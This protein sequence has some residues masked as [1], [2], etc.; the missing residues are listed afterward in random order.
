[1]SGIRLPVPIPSRVRR[2]ASPGSFSAGPGVSSAGPDGYRQLPVARLLPG[3]RS[4]RPTGIL[5]SMHEA[6]PPAQRCLPRTGGSPPPD[7][8]RLGRTGDGRGCPRTSAGVLR[9]PGRTDGPPWPART[10]PYARGLPPA[11]YGPPCVPP[12]PGHTSAPPAGPAADPVE[13]AREPAPAPRFLAANASTRRRFR[14]TARAAAEAAGRPTRPRN[15]GHPAHHG[16]RGAHGGTSDRRHRTPLRL[17]G[18]RSS[19]RTVSANFRAAAHPWRNVPPTAVPPGQK[20][21]G[22]PRAPYGDWPPAHGA[23]PRPLPRRHPS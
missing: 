9:V 5:R 22:R 4:A 2:Q 20:G 3:A 15:H 14:A 18:F 17:T 23:L 1:M 10:V 19:S 13:P 6:P 12:P 21:Y 11:A 7:G 16:A 8:G